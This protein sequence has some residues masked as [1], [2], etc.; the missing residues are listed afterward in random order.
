MRGT[1]QV[2]LQAQIRG[3]RLQPVGQDLVRLLCE[4]GGRHEQ[5]CLGL[6]QD[7]PELRRREPRRQ[8]QR[9]GTRGK[10]GEEGH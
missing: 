4:L 1:A 9:D 6:V 5:A 2:L 3:L 10:D 8:G 7:I